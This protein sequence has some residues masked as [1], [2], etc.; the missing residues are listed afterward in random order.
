MLKMGARSSCVS[1]VQ[2][3][4][5]CQLDRNIRNICA[6]KCFIALLACVLMC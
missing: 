2:I 4:N 6:F 3:N 1:A 5:V